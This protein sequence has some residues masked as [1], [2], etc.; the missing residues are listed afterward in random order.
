[1]MTTINLSHISNKIKVIYSTETY[2]ISSMLLLFTGAMRLNIQ[3]GAVNGYT[4][5]CTLRQK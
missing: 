1:M 5:E 2:N 3:R 4:V